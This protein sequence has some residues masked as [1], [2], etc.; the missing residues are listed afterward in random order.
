[1]FNT[2]DHLAS[3][4]T[5]DVT[6]G[7]ID[8]HIN[9]GHLIDVSALPITSVIRKHVLARGASVFQYIAN[10]ALPQIRSCVSTG[11]SDCAIVQ[12]LTASY[13]GDNTNL[14]KLAD[15]I[16]ATKAQQQAN[17]PGVT[18]EQIN[19]LEESLRS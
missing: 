7:E 18:E 17:G 5:R 13:Q 3:Q 6:T 11:I 10:E 4:P 1:M 14:S 15:N 19:D 8:A 12:A 2:L 16:K 9:K